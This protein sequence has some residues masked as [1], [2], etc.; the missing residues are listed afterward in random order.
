MNNAELDTI[1]ARAKGLHDHSYICA[2]VSQDDIPALVAEV[3]RLRRE[4]ARL[5][6]L[7]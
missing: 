7:P 5:W 1:E 4:V 3:R 6:S 2:V